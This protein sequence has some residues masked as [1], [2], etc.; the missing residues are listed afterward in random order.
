MVEA[1]K[2]TILKALKARDVRLEKKL[3]PYK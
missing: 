1:K 2:F 3:S